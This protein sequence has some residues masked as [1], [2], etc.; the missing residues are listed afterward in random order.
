MRESFGLTH[1]LAFFVIYFYSVLAG[2]STPS[3]CSTCEVPRDQFSIAL[4]LNALITHPSRIEQY[5]KTNISEAII[6]MFT[7]WQLL[8]VRSTARV[9]DY[10]RRQK[11]WQRVLNGDNMKNASIHAPCLRVDTLRKT[12]GSRR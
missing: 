1:A 5:V 11:A 4:F 10:H 8:P 3:C 9:N 7:R 12:N 2:A 6:I